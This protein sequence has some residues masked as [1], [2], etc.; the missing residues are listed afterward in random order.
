MP[1]AAPDPETVSIPTEGGATL[2]ADLWPGGPA[3]LVLAHG[4]GLGRSAW[5]RHAP[6]LAATGLT[7]LAPDF[8]GH[9]G[10]PGEAHPAAMR[11]DIAAC[12]DWARARGAATVS[13]LGAGTGA[14]AIA[15]AVLKGMVR[16][17]HALILLAPRHI[18]GPIGMAHN[19]ILWVTAD[20]DEATVLAVQQRM[21]AAEA[22]ELAIYSGDFPAQK[23]FDSPHRKALIRRV[24]ALLAEEA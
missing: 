12:T 18:E 2:E 4:I 1:T 8:R 20:E 15:S 19:R 13:L 6:D 24:A 5:A 21:M 16:G 23:L 17:V 7:V 11:A 9:G 14:S 10:S 22:I 3:T